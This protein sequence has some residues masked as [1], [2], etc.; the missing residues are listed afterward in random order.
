MTAVSAG[1][2][3]SLGAA[4]FLA[5]EASAYVVAVHAPVKGGNTAR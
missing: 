3:N 5:W 1:D 2:S 4:A